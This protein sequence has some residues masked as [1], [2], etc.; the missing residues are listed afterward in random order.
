[1]K[2][3]PIL[4]TLLALL[5]AAPL[6]DASLSGKYKG[7][8][9]QNYKMSFKVRNGKVVKFRSGINLF[10]PGGGFQVDAVTRDKGIRIKSGGRFRA[11]GKYSDGSEYV[12]SGRIRGRK[13]KGKI[14]LNGRSAFNSSGN[15]VFCGNTA[16][17][18][19]KRR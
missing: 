3:A 1:M 16:S 7:K 2:K 18:K 12:I 10:C 17:W 9:A 14:K 5:V 8:T 13:A 6:A 4:L 11:K 15:L 19:A